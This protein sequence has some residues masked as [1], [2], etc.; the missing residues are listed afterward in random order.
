MVNSEGQV[1]FDTHSQ[2]LKLQDLSSGEKQL[3]I[4]FASLIFG[5]KGK[6]KGIFIVDE[7]EASLHLEW[8]SKFVPAILK[9]NENIQLIFATH[10][11]E[12]IGK[13]RS[14]AVKLVRL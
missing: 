12:L 2:K 11:P 7:P 13:Y 4:T 6:N 1:Y 14:K 3:I 10:S 5:L 8:Q 9:A